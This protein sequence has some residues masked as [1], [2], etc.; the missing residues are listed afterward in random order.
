M[1]LLARATYLINFNM[2]CNSDHVIYLISC[3]RCAMQYVGSTINK[4]R[5][6]FNKSRL[7]SHIK[8][9]V[10]NRVKDHHIQAL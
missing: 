8:L 3:A 1:E 7:N 6:R 4:I 10:E 9:T 2:G 5:I